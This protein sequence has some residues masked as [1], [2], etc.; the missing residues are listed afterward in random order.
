[1]WQD[2]T[3]A[4]N[5]PVVLIDGSESGGLALLDWLNSHRSKLEAFV[6]NGGRAWL[7]A[8][9][10]DV[11][12]PF[13]M[14]FGVY[15]VY[16]EP[17]PV[18]VTCAP[19]AETDP[20]YQYPH[21]VGCDMSGDSFAIGYLN[22]TGAYNYEILTVDSNNPEFIVLLRIHVGLGEVIP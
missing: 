4:L 13:H 10:S 6:E 2:P 9:A 11:T 18:Q 5:L 7:N 19:G 16:Q 22:P 17:Y 15:W 3:L 12:E 1:M 20:V 21:A 8:A 14:V